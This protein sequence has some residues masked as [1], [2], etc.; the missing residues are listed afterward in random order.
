MSHRTKLLSWADLLPIML[1]AAGAAFAQ[2]DTRV[3]VGSPT[4]PFPQNKQNEP[5]IAVNP[6]DPS[7]LAAG[8]NDE[9]DLEACNAGDP[10]SCPFTQGVGLSGIYFSFNGGTTWTQ[11]TYVGWTA[12]DCLGP[13]PCVPHVGRCL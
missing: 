1:L 9:I 11:P 10:T 4:S 3:T 6:N 13:A 7:I 8:S 12:R 5:A 2:G